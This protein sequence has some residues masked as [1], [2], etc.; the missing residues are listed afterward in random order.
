MKTC[1]LIDAFYLREFISLELLRRWFGTGIACHTSGLVVS[2]VE[3]R[4][5][6]VEEFIGPDRLAVHYTDSVEIGAIAASAHQRS[7]GMHEVS[8]ELLAAK[9]PASHPL[10]RR[11]GST[12]FHWPI[13]MLLASG[14]VSKREALSLNQRWSV[15]GSDTALPFAPEAKSGAS[16]S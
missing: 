16:A 8:I 15:R 6:S 5:L 13:E 7:C 3:E 2:K 11:H 9:I 14:L 1:L 4:G 10:I 12:N